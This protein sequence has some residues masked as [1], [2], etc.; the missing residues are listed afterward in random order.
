[1]IWLINNDLNFD[2]ARREEESKR[3][4]FLESDVISI[5]KTVQ[6]NLPQILRRMKKPRHFKTH[7]PVSLLPTGF[8]RAGPKI[9]YVAKNPK[10]AAISYFHYFKTEMGYQGTK[11]NLFEVFLNDLTLYA[12]FS[13]HVLEFWNMRNDENVLFLTFDEMKNDLRSTIS[14]AIHFMGKEYSEEQFEKLTEYLSEFELKM[15]DPD[16]DVED[17][18]NGD[19]EK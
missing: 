5:N 16:F 6:N 2:E 4:T 7:L 17:N 9:I 3:T 14:K 18:M 1:M 13:N 10:D 8:W 12:P 19:S 15:N 11:E